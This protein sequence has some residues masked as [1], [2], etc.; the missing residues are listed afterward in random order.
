MIAGKIA[1]QSAETA[2]VIEQLL[3]D[4]AIRAPVGFAQGLF[5]ARCISSPETGEGKLAQKWRL[6]SACS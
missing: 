2:H 5:G 3:I 4:T 1:D 6:C